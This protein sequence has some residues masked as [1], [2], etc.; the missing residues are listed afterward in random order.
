MK[1]NSGNS[2]GKWT[3]NVKSDF[4]YLKNK[5]VILGKSLETSSP[6]PSEN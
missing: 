1:T 4:W 5:L 6:I 2:N 3:E